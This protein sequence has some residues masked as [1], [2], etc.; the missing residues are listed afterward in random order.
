MLRNK[1]VKRLLCVIVSLFGLLLLAA[2]GMA[3]YLMARR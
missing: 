2:G 3:F 1:W